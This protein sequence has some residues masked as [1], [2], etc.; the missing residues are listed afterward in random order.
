MRYW[1]K[2]SDCKSGTLVAIWDADR[3]GYL[4]PDIFR[5]KTRSNIPIAGGSF[6]MG[7]EA[8]KFQARLN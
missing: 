3:E 7:G 2:R 1:I 6:F 4:V 8:K 5:T